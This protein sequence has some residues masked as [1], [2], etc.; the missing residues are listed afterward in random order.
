MIVMY[1]RMLSVVSWVMF[2]H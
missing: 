1:D 2:W